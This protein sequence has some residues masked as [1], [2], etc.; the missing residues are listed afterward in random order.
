M[1]VEILSLLQIDF[2][3]Y[4]TL[5]NLS[6]TLFTISHLTVRREISSGKHYVY[7]MGCLKEDTTEELNNGKTTLMDIFNDFG[8]STV[9]RVK[10]NVHDEYFG[11]LSSSTIQKILI[12][13]VIFESIQRKK[14]DAIFEGNIGGT[15]D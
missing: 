15:D 9:I 2:T 3:N 5:L 13:N 14:R 11:F 7:Y 10:G 4:G 12:D 1:G 6:E 8:I